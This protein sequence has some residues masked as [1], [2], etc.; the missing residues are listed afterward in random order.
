MEQTVTL[1]NAAIERLHR[2][3]IYIVYGLSASHHCSRHTA[4]LCKFSKAIVKKTFKYLTDRV[5]A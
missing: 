3:Y 4:Y 5:H 2:V 1:I